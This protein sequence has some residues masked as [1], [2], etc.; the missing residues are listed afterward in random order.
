MQILTVSSIP[1]FA[2]LSELIDRHCSREEINSV[3]L[4]RISSS[5]PGSN[6][7]GLSRTVRGEK[8]K[9][10][11]VTPLTL[12]ARLSIHVY[13]YTSVTTERQKNTSI[14]LY[15]SHSVKYCSTLKGYLWK[16]KHLLSNYNIQPLKNST[17]LNERISASQRNVCIHTRTHTQT[18]H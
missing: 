3:T 5:L 17:T 18:W 7:E 9:F 14:A 13:N 6:L 15:V 10:I 8:A 1:A 11:Y 16:N 4:C 12:H 2:S